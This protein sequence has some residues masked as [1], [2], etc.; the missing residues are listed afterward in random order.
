MSRIVSTEVRA[1]SGNSGEYLQLKREHGQ[2]YCRRVELFTHGPQQF[3]QWERIEAEQA[4]DIAALADDTEPIP[5]T[6][7]T[8]Q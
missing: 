7:F 1:G 4:E 5:S 8:Q 6:W 3:H 2:F